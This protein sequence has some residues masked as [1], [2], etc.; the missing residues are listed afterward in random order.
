MYFSTRP[1]ADRQATTKSGYRTAG[2]GPEQTLTPSR[3][4]DSFAVERSLTLLSD[5]QSVFFLNPV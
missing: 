4:E 2:S 5:F 1:V 3:L